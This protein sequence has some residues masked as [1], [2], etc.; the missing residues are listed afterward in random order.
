MNN[1]EDNLTQHQRAI[2]DTP[3]LAK[4]ECYKGNPLLKRGG[5][6]LA[7]TDDQIAEFAKCSQDPQYF[8]ETYIKII[9]LD[10]GII[11]YKPRKYQAE[12]I[13]KVMNN[14]FVICKFPRQSGKTTAMSSLLLWFL[15]FNEAFSIAILANKRANAQDVLSRLALAYERLPCWM[16]QGVLTWNKGG[17]EL[18]NKSDVLATGTSSSAARGGS[19]N[20]I[21]LDEFAFV[22]NNI[23]EEFFASV[24]PTI[25]SGITTR[26]LITST[27]RGMNMFYK[28]WNDAE[29]KRND[30]VPIAVKWSDVPG[31][32]EAWKA[33]EI[34]NTS[35]EQFKVEHECEFIGSINTLISSNKL[36]QLTYTQPVKQEEHTKIFKHPEAE[37][38]YMIVVDTARGVGEDYSAFTVINISKEPYEVVSVYRNNTIVPLI[39][40]NIVVAGA[41]YYNNAY[42]L[43]EVNDI[44]GQVADI[45]NQEFEYDNLLYTQWLGR[46]GQKLGGG[47]GKNAMIGC[48]TTVNLKRVGCTNLKALVEHDKLLV[49]DEDIIEELTT[50]I[51]KKE[52]FEAD[53]GCNDDLVMCLVIFSWAVDQEFFRGL[54]D[55]NIRKSLRDSNQEEIDNEN[56]PF[57]FLTFDDPM[58]RDGWSEVDDG[59][60]GF[61]RDP[62]VIE[63]Y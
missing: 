29:H 34:R 61:E 37:N 36:R 30:Y 56:T 2:R 23:Q 8:C 12:V 18:E 5:V 53:G 51:S 42:I 1:N 54:T 40:P 41:R 10:E 17:I 11:S 13:D 45:L 26:V 39:Y 52:S 62:P 15:I 35:E 14:R 6:K 57:G 33:A 63:M 24:F 7:W 9:S 4:I 16:Q 46:S 50:F 60:F 55:W 58:T 48:R 47:F 28:L 31:R 38:N 32:D 43:V 59:E 27:P 44:G 25:S 49:H 21:Y 20:L 22:Q 19:F 3:I